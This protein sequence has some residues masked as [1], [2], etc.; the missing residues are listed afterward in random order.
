[1]SAVALMLPSNVLAMEECSKWSDSV[2]SELKI[3]HI[4]RAAKSDGGASDFENRLF[5]LGNGY[6]SNPLSQLL[7]AH[8]SLEAGN[9]LSALAYAEVASHILSNVDVCSKTAMEFLSFAIRRQAIQNLPFKLDDSQVYFSL[10]YGLANEKLSLL[11]QD[12]PRASNCL[13]S[14]TLGDD[15]NLI[16]KC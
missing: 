13:S 4:E 11:S 2:Y 7:L 1:M 14:F 5:K 10:T 6:V 16:F 15:G 8:K 12:Y 3:D 9:I